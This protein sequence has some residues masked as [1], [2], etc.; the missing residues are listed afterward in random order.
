MIVDKV[1]PIE[2]A[3]EIPIPRENASDLARLTPEQQ[4]IAGFYLLF[5]MQKVLE[6]VRPFQL[7]TV[8][9]EITLDGGVSGNVTP[10]LIAI[11][12]KK[13]QE[14]AREAL[15][16]TLEETVRIAMIDVP[17]LY[18]QYQLQDDDDEERF[19]T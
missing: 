3:F 16:E 11:D 5:F 14:H 6:V 13:H 18:K 8:A 12:L 19:F 15:A 1:T 10:C 7:G 2:V 4:D 17:G 9:T